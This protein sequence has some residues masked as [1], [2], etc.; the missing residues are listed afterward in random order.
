M[1]F[2]KLASLSIGLAAFL[3]GLYLVLQ[4]SKVWRSKNNNHVKPP[5]MIAS[6]PPRIA[7]SGEQSTDYWKNEIRMAVKIA[8]EDEFRSRAKSLNAE[9]VRT[10]MKD[11]IGDW[12]DSRTK[13][14]D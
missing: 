4:I 3:G 9:E 13:K 6:E 11:V 12:L 14:R 8:I 1:D 2:S 5:L 7:T 10:I